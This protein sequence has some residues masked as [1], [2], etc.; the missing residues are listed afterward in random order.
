MAHT[1]VTVERWHNYMVYGCK[2]D[3]VAAA[4]GTLRKLGRGALR[5]TFTNARGDIVYKVAHQS[6][7]GTPNRSEYAR[8]LRIAEFDRGLSTPCSLYTVPTNDGPVLVLA[9]VTRPGESVKADRDTER[10]F[11]AR[12]TRYNDAHPSDRIRDMHSD[13]W[14]LTPRGRATVTDVGDVVWAPRA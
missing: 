11:T 1:N 8:M 14:R 10:R 5:A 7:F 6:T 12:I 13:N 4:D 2:R 9:M 3:A